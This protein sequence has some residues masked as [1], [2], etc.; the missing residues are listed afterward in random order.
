MFVITVFKIGKID[1]TAAIITLTLGIITVIALYYLRP[2]GAFLIIMLWLL[3]PVFL[4][5]FLDF[6]RKKLNSKERV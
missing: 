2:E 6:I 4:K 5:K 1:K 3:V